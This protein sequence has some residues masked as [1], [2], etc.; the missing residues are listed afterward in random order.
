M[1]KIIIILTI[2]LVS[3]NINAEDKKTP[4]DYIIFNIW[5]DDHF[6]NLD[7]W[8]NIRVPQLEGFGEPTLPYV[9]VNHET[10]TFKEYPNPCPTKKSVYN[11]YNLDWVVN[12]FKMDAHVEDYAKYKLC[13]EDYLKQYFIGHYNP[14]GN[15]SHAWSLKNKL[16]EILNPKPVSYPYGLPSAK[17]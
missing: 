1:K 13:V 12:K 3:F 15:F 4:G 6:R 16:V 2:I 8:R 17:K 10:K 5:G 9:E 7:A 11:L 14:K